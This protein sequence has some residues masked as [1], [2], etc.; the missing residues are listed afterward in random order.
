M[1]EELSKMLPLVA[2]LPAVSNWK[3]AG[4]M[5]AKPESEVAGMAKDVLMI[6][7]CRLP[8]RVCG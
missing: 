8:F 2:E 6:G 1:L 5:A 4:L 3:A 7:A